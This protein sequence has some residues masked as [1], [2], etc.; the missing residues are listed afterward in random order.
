MVV[1]RIRRAVAVGATLGAL[2]GGATVPAYAAGTTPFQANF[3]EQTSFVACP[4]GV[5]SGARCFSGHG[6]GAA[7]PGGT[8]TE[9]FVGFVNAAAANPLTGCAPDYSF[10][11]IA[12]Q[13]GTLYLA[14]SG[15]SCQTGPT[16]AVDTETFQAIGGTGTFEG[17][18]GTGSVSTAG[19]FNPNGTVSSTTSYTGGLRLGD[20]S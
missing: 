7:V 12:T 1:S 13:S 5:P 18:R 19:T 11:T 14:A 3:A 6:T 17:A 16:T 2:V 15:T 4:P 10:V 9:S 8:A 20:G